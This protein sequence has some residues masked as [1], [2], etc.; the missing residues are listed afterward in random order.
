MQ[1]G[2]LASYNDDKQALEKLY[3][4]QPEV[5][6]ITQ[7]YSQLINDI[8][9]QQEENTKEREQLNGLLDQY[10]DKYASY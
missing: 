8:K 1:Q 6:A 9:K 5:K 3:Y 2:E 4:E 7:K 10:E